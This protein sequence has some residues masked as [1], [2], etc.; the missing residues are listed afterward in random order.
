[1]SKLKKE[2]NHSLTDVTTSLELKLQSLSKQV[3]SLLPTNGKDLEFRLFRKKIEDYQF[4][5]R[6]QGTMTIAR[7]DI[8]TRSV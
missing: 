6:C 1:M 3:A 7:E 5:R 4:A 2:A 8:A